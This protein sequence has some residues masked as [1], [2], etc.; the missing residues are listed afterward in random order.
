[1]GTSKNQNK[2]LRANRRKGKQVLFVHK[3]RRMQHDFKHSNEPVLDIDIES[4]FH[5]ECYGLRTL[6]SAHKDRN[7]LWKDKGYKRRPL[8]GNRELYKT[9]E[10]D[11]VRH[12][13]ET[14]GYDDEANR[15]AIADDYDKLEKSI[16]R[17]R[18]LCK[19]YKERKVA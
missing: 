13:H 11:K 17:R 15:T 1:M 14:R 12:A 7:G 5:E 9:S 18:V 2:R 8:C 3:I 6:L 4:M 16:R 19:I 10:E